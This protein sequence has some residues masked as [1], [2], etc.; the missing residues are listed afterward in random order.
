M[1]DPFGE[2]FRGAPEEAHRRGAGALSANMIICAARTLTSSQV[3][4]VNPAEVKRIPFLAAIV[5]KIRLKLA[6][7]SQY[8]PVARAVANSFEESLV[9]A[10]GSPDSRAARED[11]DPPGN[12]EAAAAQAAAN[13]RADSP[14]QRKR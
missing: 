12:A 6:E 9:G 4:G 1:R 13:H 2:T 14:A 3:S 8:H 5:G 11:A 7:H 10:G